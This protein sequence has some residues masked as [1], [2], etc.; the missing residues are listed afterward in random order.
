MSTKAPADTLPLTMPRSETAAATFEFGPGPLGLVLLDQGNRVV[1][2][3]DLRRMACLASLEAHA[4]S[5]EEWPR[6]FDG[7]SLSLLL[8]SRRRFFV[9]FL[10]FF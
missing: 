3:P 7:S 4:N 8:L 9:C 1:I 6:F 5:L 2:A 10:S